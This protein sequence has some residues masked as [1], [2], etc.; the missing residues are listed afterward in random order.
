MALGFV[1]VAARRRA[2]VVVFAFLVLAAGSGTLRGTRA[3]AAPSVR[4]AYGGPSS[5]IK[6]A[7][8][9]TVIASPS[10][11]TLDSLNAAGLK[12]VVWL[13]QYSNSSCTFGTSETSLTSTVQNLAGHP[14]VAAWQISDE[15]KA[16]SCPSSPQQHRDRTALIHR[17]DTRP[18]YTVIS[19]WDGQDVY[20]YQ[21]FAGTTD[22][23]GIDVYI[24]RY[25][26][27]SCSFSMIDTAIAEA[28]KDGVPHYWAV[29]QGFGDSYYRMPTQA[30]MK[31]QFVRWNRSRMEGYLLYHWS[32]QGSFMVDWC[33]KHAYCVEEAKALNG[34]ST[35]APSPTSP[36]PSPSPSP[37]P[38]AG[39]VSGLTLVNAD[40]DGDVG[41]LRAGDILDTSILGT[42]NFSV[43][44]S[45][46]GAV[47]SVRFT[48][49]GS[50][51]KTESLAPYAL[52]GD[53]GTDY[54][55]WSAPAG[56][57]TL[58]V[59]PYAG[60]DAT[61]TAGA[62]V[63]VTFTVVAG[64]GDTTPPT[65]PGALGVKWVRKTAVLSWTAASDNVGVVAYRVYRDGK[66]VATTTSLA[67]KDN[68]V[69]RLAHTYE[70]RAVDAAGNASAPAVGLLGAL[71]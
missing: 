38:T 1:R 32:Q 66:L 53:I 21:K 33:A 17:Y 36:A 9:N 49:D 30:E 67:Y 42:H 18:T 16:T 41:P 39:S 25:S 6:A 58:T 47:E 43:R 12:A 20:P 55:P 22:I 27:T 59:T 61:G 37:T 7:G 24:C 8:F 31:E 68:P 19:T 28:D 34:G 56:P 14:A 46:S 13:G 29:P 65:A 54:L 60:N 57:H 71:R 26:S 50:V 5:D 40:S 2:V 64:V 45:V 63:T 4:G 44:A 70:V 62:P 3:V 10:R 35:A 15:P 51:V 69:W 48:L 52:M 11:S 23:M